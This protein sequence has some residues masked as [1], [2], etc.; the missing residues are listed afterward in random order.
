MERV[1]PLV[2]KQ[3]EKVTEANC[4]AEGRKRNRQ[5]KKCAARENS[6]GSG[7]QE[8]EARPVQQSINEQAEPRARRKTHAPVQHDTEMMESKPQREPQRGKGVRRNEIDE[9]H[10]RSRLAWGNAEGSDAS[11]SDYGAGWT[12]GE[13]W[14]TVEVE[15][16]RNAWRGVQWSR[17]MRA[18]TVKKG[19]RSASIRKAIEKG[20]IEWSA[21]KPV[22]VAAEVREQEESRGTDGTARHAKGTGTV[23]GV[24]NQRQARSQEIAPRPRRNAASFFFFVGRRPST[25][26]IVHRRLRS[27]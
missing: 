25:S 17:V 22:G 12:R 5:H 26:S 7:G 14:F 4:A 2:T 18:E 19:M 27:P 20:H 8:G 16:C 10:A 21:E 23:R 11:V 3:W 1:A 13:G 6:N 24:V 9:R 15:V